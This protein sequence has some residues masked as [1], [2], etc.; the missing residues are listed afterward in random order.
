MCEQLSSYVQAITQHLPCNSKLQARVLSRLL[1]ACA[2]PATAAATSSSSVPAA[3]SAGASM[4]PGVR[5][6]PLLSQALSDYVS[7]ITDSEVMHA[8]MQDL[9]PL[10]Q[11]LLAKQPTA[12]QPAVEACLRALPPFLR[13]ETFADSWLATLAPL[14]RV[15]LVPS[16]ALAQVPKARRVTIAWLFGCR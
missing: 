13:D 1:H 7:Q 3:G 5:V 14:L 12:I 4:A 15:I 11:D 16:H 2:V 8:A 6:P 9:L 10:L